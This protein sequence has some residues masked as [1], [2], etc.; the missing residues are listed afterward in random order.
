MRERIG[1]DPALRP[2]LDRVV[3]DGAGRTQSL[4]DVAFF[5]DAFF[6]VDPV[7][8]Y[9]RETVSLEFHAYL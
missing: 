9:A 3:A 5:E 8:P 4:L 7:G 1:H 6:S 2:P